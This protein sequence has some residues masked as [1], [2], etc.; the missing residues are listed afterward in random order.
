MISKYEVITIH[1]YIFSFC[2]VLVAHDQFRFW[3]W[4]ETCSNSTCMWYFQSYLEGLFKR[5]FTEG[6]LNNEVGEVLKVITNLIHGFAQMR[7]SHEEFVCLQVI[8][9]LSQSKWP[10]HRFTWLI[11]Y[12][13]TCFCHTMFVFFWVYSRGKNCYP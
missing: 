13:I 7:L 12:V 5:D 2:W 1:N 4:C 9:L 6:Q 11:S 8:L 3:L 10:Y